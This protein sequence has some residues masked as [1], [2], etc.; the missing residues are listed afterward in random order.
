MVYVEGG[1]NKGMGVDNGRIIVM[2]VMVGWRIYG[3]QTTFLLF[4][5]GRE[6]C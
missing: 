4:V 3:N 1:C 5:N 6:Y 2:I